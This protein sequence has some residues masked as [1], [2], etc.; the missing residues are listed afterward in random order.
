MAGIPG[1]IH[2]QSC[3]TL[4]MAQ[5]THSNAIGTSDLLPMHWLS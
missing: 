5:N 4:G 3:V 2:L 1:C